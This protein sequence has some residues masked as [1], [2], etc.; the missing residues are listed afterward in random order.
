MSEA[1]YVTPDSIKALYGP[2]GEVVLNW[3]L[4]EAAIVNL[5]AI[6][7]QSAGG[8]HLGEKLP[9]AFK[10]RSKFLRLCSRTI[11]ELKPFEADIV[12]TMD[13]A[14]HLAQVRNTVIHGAISAFDRETTTYTLWM[15]DTN[16]A[17]NIHY[18]KRVNVTPP[19]LRQA[20]VEM[21]RLTGDIHRLTEKLM[22][23]F[24]R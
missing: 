3:G 20:S 14:T 21:I 5:L 11:A 15:V 8:K 13:R 18:L 6:V 17:E 24:M 12:T 22:D 7:Y 4:V 16:D 19:A 10:R 23:T 2:V 9:V 1:H